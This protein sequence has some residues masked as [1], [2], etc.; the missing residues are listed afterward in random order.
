MKKST[1]ASARLMALALALTPLACSNTVEGVKKDAKEN[2]I[3]EKAEKAVETVA[4]AAREA[5]HEIRVHALA[6][7]IK[8]ALMADKKV[9]AGGISVDA[10]DDTRTVTLKG[11]VPTEAQRDIAEQTARKK[12]KGYRVRNLLT[13]GRA[14]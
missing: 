2:K 14:D 5:G 13:V 4:Q 8:A 1:S 3:E 9:D 6:I 10:D 7:E 12:A 11:S